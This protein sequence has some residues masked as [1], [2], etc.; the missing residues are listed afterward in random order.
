MNMAKFFRPSLLLAL[1]LLLLSATPASAEKTDWADKD[2]DFSNEPR[3]L[4]H[5]SYGSVN[6]SLFR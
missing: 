5:R 6:F 4:E 2:Y 1:C 3:F